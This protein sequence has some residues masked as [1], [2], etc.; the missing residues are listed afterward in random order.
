MTNLELQKLSEEAYENA[1]HEVEEV[2]EGK[3]YTIKEA[4]AMGA[5]ADPAIEGV[6]NE[7]IEGKEP[8]ARVD[9]NISIFAS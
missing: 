4:E 6:I 5:F 2:Y 3:S 7:Y 9:D 1:K 8:E